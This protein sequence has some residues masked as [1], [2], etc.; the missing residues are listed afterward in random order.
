MPWTVPGRLDEGALMTVASPGVVS[1]VEVV[2]AVAAVMGP[3]VVLR[4]LFVMVVEMVVELSQS[5]AA[6]AAGVVLLSELAA[7]AVTF[8]G[9][10]QED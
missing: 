9:A 4:V 3:A 1:R 10:Q 6:A 2:V 5:A 7:S 8:M